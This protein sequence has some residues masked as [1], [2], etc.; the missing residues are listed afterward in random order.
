MKLNYKA[1]RKTGGI[2]RGVIEAKDIMDAARYLRNRNFLPITVAPVNETLLN[3]P[4]L[5][6]TKGSDVI[7]FTRQLSSMLASGLTIMQAL[8][9]LKDQIQNQA[10]SD[11]VR[12]IIVDIEEGGSLSASIS[13]Y[14]KT[15]SGVYVSIIKASETAGLLDKALERLAENL[16]KQQRLKNTIK[17]ALLYPIVVVI[18]MIIVVFIM[19]VFVIPQL[20][21]LY[22]GLNVELPLPTKII[23]ALSSFFVTF[24]PFIFGFAAL[25]LFMYLR[26]RRTENGRL[27][28]DNLIL[29]IP[30]FGKIIK[31]TIISEFSRTLGLLIGA[32]TLVVESLNQSSDTTGNIHYK[33]AIL[34]VSKRV[35][36]GITM[37][38]AMGIYTLFPSMLVEMVRIGEKTGKVDESL[39]RVSEYYEREVD[40]RVKNLTS[41]LEP[42]IIVALGIG[43][44]FLI[45]SI[46]TPIYKLTSAL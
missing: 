14:P 23:I 11:I 44:A 32:G 38:D 34:G 3:L 33:N 29:K 18:G 2:V 22:K 43:V 31:D 12:E 1:I 6:K 8:S 27:I 42:I 35:E 36:R 26:W 10:M 13:R 30:I 28:I 17:S 9:I 24:W 15:F 19:M 39:L 20:N 5:Y 7:F 25:L 4:F 40:Y 46:I 45:I 37:G 16:E 41:L 21:N